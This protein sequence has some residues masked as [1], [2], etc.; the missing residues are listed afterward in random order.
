MFPEAT[1][2]CGGALADFRRAGF[3]AAIDAAVVVLP[4]T[5]TY[6]DRQ[7]RQTAAPAFVGDE[8]LLAAIRRTV[9]LRDLTVAVHWLRPVPAIAGTGQWAK[10]RARV[11]TL[12]ESAIACDLQVPVIRR[13][14]RAVGL[15]PLRTLRPAPGTMIR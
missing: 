9:A 14:A 4:V 2:R 15:P 12:A 1:T 5:L 8:T 7:G 13:Q 3:Q 11:S 10:D 6:R